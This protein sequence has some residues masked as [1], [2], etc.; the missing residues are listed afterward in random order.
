MIYLNDVG[1]EQAPFEYLRRA[2]DG[3]VIRV[4]PSWP[5]KYPEGRVPQELIDRYKKEGYESYAATGKA[6]TVLVF[7]DKII[8]KGNYAKQGFRDVLV[9]QLEPALFRKK[10]YIDP[11][12]TFSF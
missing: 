7:D 10:K 3:G 12:Y 11:R 4:S 9:L 8:H 2:V 1:L 6:G 5:R